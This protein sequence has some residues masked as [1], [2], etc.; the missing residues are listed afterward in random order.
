MAMW[1]VLHTRGSS[2]SSTKAGAWRSCDAPELHLLKQP[3]RQED[4]PAGSTPL[5]YYAA[6]ELGDNHWPTG[7]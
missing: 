2:S 1:Y 3:A 6:Y 5:I 7:E 4:L